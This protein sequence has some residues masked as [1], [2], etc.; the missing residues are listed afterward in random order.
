MQKKKPKARKEVL[1]SAEIESRYPDEWILVV[2]PT[3]DAELEVVSGTV[4][5]HSKDRDE[6]YQKLAELKPKDSAMLFT[7]GWPPGTAVVL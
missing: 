2:D 5:C 3:L 1:T 6:V 4:V 7:G